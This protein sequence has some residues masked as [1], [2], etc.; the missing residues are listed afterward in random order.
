VGST[1]VPS[2]RQL[3]LRVCEVN[4]Y[5]WHRQTKQCAQLSKEC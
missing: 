3:E 4:C 2:V 5:H 1:P